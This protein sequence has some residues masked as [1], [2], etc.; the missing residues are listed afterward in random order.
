MP[1]HIIELIG[2]FWVALLSATLLPL[3][4]EL[5]FL[6]MFTSHRYQAWQLLLFASTGNII[7][8]VV[9]WCLGRSITRFEDRRWFPIKRESIERAA[10]RF[11]R[12]G[13]WSLLLSW[14]P[15]IGD[16]LTMIAGILKMPLWRFSLWV[17][18]AKTGRYVALLYLATGVGL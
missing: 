8:S 17:G 3:Q 10:A 6:G 7:G 18:V 13:E 9:N 11:R 16:P 14:L 12:Y 15:I 5:V 1:S 4:S 2:L